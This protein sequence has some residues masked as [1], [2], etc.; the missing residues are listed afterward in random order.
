MSIHSYREL[1]PHVGHDIVC[2]TYGD[3]AVNVALECE[4]CEEILIDYERQPD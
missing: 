3:N 4:T 2:V 1:I